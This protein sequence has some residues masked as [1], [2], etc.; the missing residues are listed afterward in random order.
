ML[1]IRRG[2]NKTLVLIISGVV[3]HGVDIDARNG[4][5]TGDPGPWTYDVQILANMITAQ[6]AGNEVQVAL[7]Q[8]PLREILLGIATQV[9][10]TAENARF[11]F[12]DATRQLV[13]IQNARIGRALDAEANVTAIVM[14]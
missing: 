7:K 8:E 6:R 14:T 9:D 2:P 11:F 1:P 4:I 12:D 3:V 10:R 13:L 5:I